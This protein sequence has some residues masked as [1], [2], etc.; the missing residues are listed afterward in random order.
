MT[1]SLTRLRLRLTLWYAGTFTLILLLLGGGLLVAIRHHISRRLDD[2]LRAATAAVAAAT[3]TLEVERAAGG[4]ADA[5]EELHIPDRVLYLFDGN[6]HPI[7]PSTVDGWIQ[8][9]AQDA[10]RTGQLDLDRDAPPPGRAR[11]AVA[12]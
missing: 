2:S 3:K 10:A 6:G 4:A 9:A 11:R 12:R 5:V 1:P 8:T 7:T